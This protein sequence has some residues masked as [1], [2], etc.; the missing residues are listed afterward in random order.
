M[1][2]APIGS[3]NVS[4]M[5]I[6]QLL[7]GSALIHMIFACLIKQCKR[8]LT[9]C[10]Q[11]GSVPNF[12]ALLYFLSQSLWYVCKCPGRATGKCVSS[13]RRAGSGSREQWCFFICP[14]GKMQWAG[15]A[16][17]CF[18]C[19]HSTFPLPLFLSPLS[20]LCTH[21]WGHELS[22]ILGRSP[23]TH[24]GSILDVPLQLVMVLRIVNELGGN[25]TT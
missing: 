22:I 7:L 21:W 14:I 15:Q 16:T 5:L 4:C 25:W 8:S 2:V 12:S 6:E 19:R 9:V 17:P 10:G 11:C 18:S 3:I 23:F 20:P 1:Y 24:S 13:N